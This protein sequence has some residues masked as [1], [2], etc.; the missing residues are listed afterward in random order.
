MPVLS[1]SV[2]GPGPT[3]NRRTIAEPSTSHLW[4]DSTKMVFGRPGAVQSFV[5]LCN[6]L[7]ELG[8]RVAGLAQGMADILG[9]RVAHASEPVGVPLLDGLK[10][11]REFGEEQSRASFSSRS[12]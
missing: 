12:A 3:S 4:R 8:F 6:E 10:R 7:S 1:S 2:T 11:L 5:L 9:P